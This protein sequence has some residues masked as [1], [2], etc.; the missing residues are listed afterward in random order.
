[1]ACQDMVSKAIRAGLVSSA[2]DISE[3][4]LAIA[5]AE[6]L[7]GQNH[8]SDAAGLG[9]EIHLDMA[10]AVLLFSESQS[11]FV[12]SVPP[13]HDETFL[14]TVDAVRIGRVNDTGRLVVHCNNAKI[15]DIP[16][17]A[18]RKRWKEAIP[19]SLK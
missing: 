18:M 19:C 3:G 15:A 9:A 10:D 13:G 12:V 11:R 7:I 4:G 8:E 16:V 6:S 1:K 5:L 17:E 14:R 2:H